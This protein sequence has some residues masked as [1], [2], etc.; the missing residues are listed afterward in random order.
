MS[1]LMVAGDV[2]CTCEVLST[3]SLETSL[4]PFHLHQHA[5]HV[6]MMKYLGLAL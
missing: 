5:N 3:C 1:R 2:Y 4:V 6:G